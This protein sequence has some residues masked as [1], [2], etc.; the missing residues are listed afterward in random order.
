MVSGLQ[1]SGAVVRFGDVRAVDGVD[2]TLAPGHVVALLGPSG[3]GKS[4]LLR[5]I[6]GL[7]PLS[8]GSVSW[9]GQDLARV[10]VHR[11]GFG[12]VFQDGQLFGN[13]DVGRNIAYGLTRLDAAARRR[14]VSEMLE[15]VDLAGYERRKVTELSGGQAQRVALARSLAPS[16]RLL[17]LDEP[18]S[19]L[20]H[21]L[22]R[23]L[24][25]EVSRILRDVGTTAVYVTH[26]QEEASMVGDTVAV[27]LEGRIVQADTP[28]ALW[29]RPTSEAVAR[30]LGNTAF[31]DAAEARSLGWT[32]DLP[33]G[34]VLGVGQGSLVLVDD[35]VAVPVVDEGFVL[36]HVQIGV[37]LPGG[38]RAVV[39]S[40]QR[41]GAPEVRVRLTGGAIVPR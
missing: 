12:V 14:R 2:L 13:M 6:A 7:Q 39:T 19:A 9:D 28:D 29:R 30:F 25:Q 5:A 16:P 36:G 24:A 37:R 15:L 4:T 3:S 10:K 31:I 34:H 41:A 18:L 27:M 35:G 8:R 40:E 26:D 17:L 32:G 38:Q 11:R 20:E 33:P 22:R 1:V 23:Y 21:G